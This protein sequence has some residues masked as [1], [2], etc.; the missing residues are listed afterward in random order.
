MKILTKENASELLGGE[1]G[2]FCKPAI[3]SV[4]PRRRYIFDF[5][6]CWEKDSAVQGFRIPASQEV[7]RLRICDRLGV[8][9]SSENLDVFT[10]TGVPSARTSL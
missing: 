2:Y 7:K 8:W 3:E 4:A 9:G 10:D 6:R 5:A 1:S